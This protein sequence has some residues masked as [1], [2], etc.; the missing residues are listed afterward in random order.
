MHLRIVQQ[1][2]AGSAEAQ[3]PASIR[4][5]SQICFGSSSDP[6][7]Y[8]DAFDVPGRF[9]V[10]RREQASTCE[11]PPGGFSLRSEHRLQRR[12]HVPREGQVMVRCNV[13]LAPRNLGF[14]TQAMEEQRR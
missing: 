1:I 14:P 5:Q 4:F 13:M 9:T 6:D 10:T 2:V 8:S 7:S 12:G 11:V 3:R